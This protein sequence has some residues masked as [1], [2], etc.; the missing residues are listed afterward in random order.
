MLP[1]QYRYIKG[2]RV[3]GGTS[4]YDKTTKLITCVCRQCGKTWEHKQ[5]YAYDY[6]TVCKDCLKKV[7]KKWNS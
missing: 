3:G 5:M 1:S 4:G 2:T 7:R 6:P